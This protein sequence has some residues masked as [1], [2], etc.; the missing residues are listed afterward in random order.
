M[1]YYDKRGYKRESSNLVHRHRAYH[2]IYL[3]DRKKYPLSFEAYDVH[4]IDGDKTNNKMDNLA[5]LTPEEHDKAH[6]LLRLFGLT[7]NELD[8]IKKKAIKLGMNQN[9]FEEFMDD[10]DEVLKEIWIS[11]LKKAYGKD[12][13]YHY[14]L[15]DESEIYLKESYKNH[16]QIYLQ[17][18][19]KLFKNYVD[20]KERI[21]RNKER[22][23]KIKSGVSKGIKGVKSFF[24]K[25]ENPLYCIDCGRAINHI[26]RCLA[27]N[28]KA[29]RKI[30]A[31]KKRKH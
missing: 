24:A 8:E 23:D 5:V 2:Y 26:G 12:W 14:N 25:K 18:W 20:E 9:S 28:M 16:R 31:Q 21:R 30:E 13:E 15:C 11:I 17:A 19:D 22:M 7:Q 4:H 1:A 6:E 27:C 29:K 10:F 3:K